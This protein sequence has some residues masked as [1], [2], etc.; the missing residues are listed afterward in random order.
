MEEK[1]KSLI[2]IS[3]SQ[4]GSVPPYSWSESTSQD[5]GLKPDAIKMTVCLSAAS[6]KVH[7]PRSSAYGTVGP[8]PKKLMPNL[9][10]SDEFGS[11]VK[12]YEQGVH[13]TGYYPGLLRPS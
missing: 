6:G 9:S 7:S 4:D 5:S 11:Q 2:R 8:F 10:V 12:L 1:R 13:L 3:P